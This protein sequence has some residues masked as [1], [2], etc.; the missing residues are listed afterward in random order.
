MSTSSRLFDKETEFSILD[1]YAPIIR[2]DYPIFKHHGTDTFVSFKQ[3]SDDLLRDVKSGETFSNWYEI[4]TAYSLEWYLD[5]L[6]DEDTGKLLKN[7]TAIK[8]A[9]TIKWKNEILTRFDINELLLSGLNATPKYE[10]C[11]FGSHEE[12]YKK[13]QISKVLHE[14]TV[15]KQIALAYMYDVFPLLHSMD[16]SRAVSKA[17]S[18]IEQRDTA[19]KT[20]LK[21]VEPFEEEV[22]DALWKNRDQSVE[23]I[24]YLLDAIKTNKD[25]L[26]RVLNR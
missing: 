11:F 1:F 15:K 13:H 3:A 21:E 7:F 19:A 8:E 2:D 16:T 17:I 18:F 9:L 5:E 14:E 26:I 6:V 20:M 22:R 25:Y 23:Q 24:T 4:F 10:R 12:L